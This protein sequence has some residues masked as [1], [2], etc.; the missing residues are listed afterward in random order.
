MSS[1]KPLVLGL[2]GV[3]RSGKDSFAT[4]LIEHLT[5]LGQPVARWAFADQLKRELEP[6]IRAK[7]GLSVW[8]QV[9][10]EKAVFRDDLVAHGRLRRTESNGTYWVNQIDASVRAGLAAGV[11]QIITDCRYATHEADEADWIKSLGGKVVYVERVLT[12][13]SILEPANE[14]ERLN[15]FRVKA[16]ADLVVTLPTFLENPLDNLRPYVLD[17]WNQL[18][19]ST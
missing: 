18:V 8:S 19:K 10:A 9:S 13:G 7:Y 3:A 5:L 12:D 2:S 15:T 4:L 14:E 6:I 16:Q 11:H 17:A 1:F